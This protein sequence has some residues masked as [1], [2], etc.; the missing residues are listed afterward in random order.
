M[1]G[2]NKSFN[3]GPIFW[4][5]LVSVIVSGGLSF[6]LGWALY[7]FELGIAFLIWTHMLGPIIL[8]LG[9]WFYLR[10]GPPK[11]RRVDLQR[12]PELLTEYL[13]NILFQPGPRVRLW[14]HEGSGSECLWFERLRVGPHSNQEL[15]VTSAWLS[16]T[17]AEQ[18]VQDWNIL[19][20][21]MAALNRFHRSLRSVQMLIWMS[22]ASM[23]SPLLLLFDTVLRSTKIMRGVNS[24]FFVQYWAWRLK[25]RC[26]EEHS[27]E[28]IHFLG[29]SK[30][31]SYPHPKIWNSLIWGVWFQIPSRALH[32]LWKEL[33]HSG[34]FLKD[35]T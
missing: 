4:K 17:P 10:L 18:K 29:P 23:L 25:L 19:W 26:F 30:H 13:K 22:W 31:S 7:S 11:L 3:A 33:T 21:E 32:P 35:P 12:E 9:F 5:T 2:K 14:I 8:P 27:P 1:T 34:A 28:P 16:K 15:L 24:G 20:K 6:G